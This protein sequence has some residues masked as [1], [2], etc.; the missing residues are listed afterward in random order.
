MNGITSPDRI[1]T[2]RRRLLAGLGA[3][4]LASAWSGTAKSATSGL[5]V[6][7][8]NG[9]L[10][11][12]WDRTHDLDTTQVRQTAQVIAQATAILKSAGIDTAIM[13]IPSKARTYRQFLP[14]NTRIAPEVDRRYSA[15]QNE[16]RRPGVILPDLDTAF[17]SRAASTQLFFKSDTHWTPMG[18]ELAAIEVAKAVGPTL[19][20]SNL[21]GTQVSTLVNK[22]NPRGDL[23]RNLPEAQRSGYSP[24]PYQIREVVMTGGQNALIADDT[25]DVAIVGNS[26]MEPRYGFQPVLSNQLSRPV[27]L[28]W[29]PNNVG[30][31]AT[32]LQYVT[33]EG[34]RQQRP[35]VIAWT[36]LEFDIPGLPT[37][38]GW[39]QNAMSTDKF[40]GDL[41]RAVG[42]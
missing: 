16:L 33:S 5:T 39:R 32:L 10:F 30:P 28:Y 6:V 2:S 27:A 1:G 37:S 8:T 41:R 38:S 36:H 35:K 19:P 20:R 7:G 12:V 15:V 11:A 26:Y 29:K 23:V 18:A 14:S 42:A 34:F 17:R 13:L 31:F 4:G 24:E 22:T 3:T 9:W 21:P 25:A 40:L